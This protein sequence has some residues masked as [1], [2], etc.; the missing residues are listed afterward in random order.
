MVNTFCEPVKSITDND[1]NR[2]YVLKY[3][4]LFQERISIADLCKRL[5]YHLNTS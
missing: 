2:L 5:M 4:S 1:Q 3:V